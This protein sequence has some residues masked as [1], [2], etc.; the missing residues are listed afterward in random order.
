MS[1]SAPVPNKES[2]LSVDS[3]S[4][5]L[6]KGGSSIPVVDQLSLTLRPGE[7]VGLVGESGC[8][9]SVT[10]YS[11]LRLLPPSLAR[12][13]TGQVTFNGTALLELPESRMREIRGRDLSMIFQEPQTALNPV[14]TIGRQVTEVIQRHRKMD[15][16]AA[17]ALGREM[18]SHTGIAD[19]ERVMK[20]YPHQLSGGM[21]QRA[22]IAMATAC[23]PKVLLADEP[24]TALDV[25]TQAQVLEQLVKLGRE[26]GTAILL[27]THDLG[28]VAQ[29]CDRALVMSQGRIVEAAT[30][31]D[32]FALP[33]HP[34]T[35]ELLQAIP[36]IDGPGPTAAGDS[37]GSRSPDQP[38]LL[39]VRE[40][41][42]DYPV[43][44]HRGKKLVAV[45]SVS[46]DIQPG[47]IFGLVG[48]SGSG[49]TSVARAI[50][51]L[52]TP[53]GGG[54]QFDGEQ[55]LDP[56]AGRSLPSR[57]DIQLVFQ[58]PY[59]SLSP[60]RTIRQSLLEPL[61][62]FGIGDR[63]ERPSRVLDAL[64]SV[65]LR[66]EILHRYPNELSGGQRQR[67]ALARALVCEP[68]LII[69]DEAVY[70]LDVLVQAR[71]LELILKVREQSG[72]AFLFISHDLAVIRQL[73][74]VVG[75]MYL[76][77]ILEQAPADSLFRNA[78]H[79]Y[80][81]SLLEAVPCPDPGAATPTAL[82]GEAPSPLTPPP[83]C[84][85]HTRCNQVIEPCRT[86]EPEKTMLAGSENHHTPHVVRCHLCN[87]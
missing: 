67:V 44:G 6:G 69:A 51:R 14:Q 60:R 65:G 41:T 82:R 22:L 39:S 15:R 24:T 16:G 61:N 45:N 31:S 29:Y 9:K 52:V 35:I 10:A 55:L 79:P 23:K 46:F 18:L 56:P 64:E 73:A 48:E 42:V 81:R 7:I 12:Q 5:S 40:L 32:L 25:T 86:T 77:K 85:F 33:S 62:H 30:V 76:G 13:V 47:E 28:L 17:Q 49:K 58:D 27:I 54:I 83:G 4:V 78:S 66:T 3:L 50:A 1:Q 8:G 68:R 59:A 38:P 21:R 74:D 87:S 2:V 34:H 63:S 19:A 26:A 11:L 70:S 80:T 84:V 37:S 36:R 75:V 57:K 20:S 53:A 43:A 71:I 72:V